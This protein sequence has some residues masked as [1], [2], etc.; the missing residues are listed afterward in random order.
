MTVKGLM[1]DMRTDGHNYKI[2]NSLIIHE[3][4]TMGRNP[5][6]MHP[7][8]VVGRRIFERDMVRLV[9]NCL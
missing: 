2:D 4:A 9:V 1:Q 6:F 3:I 8:L 7:C 5:K